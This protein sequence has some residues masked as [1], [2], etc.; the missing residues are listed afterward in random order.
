MKEVRMLVAGLAL[1]LVAAVS[2]EEYVCSMRVGTPTTSNDIGRSGGKSKG[3]GGSSQVKTT[4]TTQTWPV[5]ISFT[6]K[7]IP[8]EGIKL[9]CTYLGMTKGRHEI[10]GQKTVE[11]K[12]DEKGCYKGEVTSPEAVMTKTK[13]TTTSGGGNGRRGGHGGRGGNNRGNRSSSTKSE[14]SGTRI[15]G[16][17]LQLTVNGEI[18]KGYASSSEWSRLAKKKSITESDLQAR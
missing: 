2:G 15:V 9:E 13:T 14:T 16:C 3:K 11:I 7:S 18:V 6:G 12:L 8:T 4:K 1:M 17:V 5:S 10:L